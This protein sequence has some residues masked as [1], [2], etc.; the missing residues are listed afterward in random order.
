MYLWVVV[1]NK[2]ARVMKAFRKK[3]E[4]QKSLRRQG[5][6]CFDNIIWSRTREDIS[7]V[8]PDTF[9]IQRLLVDTKGREDE[10]YIKHQLYNQKEANQ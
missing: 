10:R 1:Q 9:S 6:S 5:I 7:V 2:T 8:P 3:E 4:A